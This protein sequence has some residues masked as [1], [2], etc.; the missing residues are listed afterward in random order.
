MTQNSVMKKSLYGNMF[1]VVLKIIGGFL[2]NSTALLADGVHSIS[3]LISDVFVLLGIKHSHKPADDDHPFGHGKFEYVLS[4]FLGL[5]IIFIAIELAINVIQDWSSVET[6]P[7]FGAL[8]LVIFVIVFKFFL[9]S[10][11]IKSGKTMDSQVIQASGKESLTDVVSSTV[12]LLGIALVI[13]GDH[14]NIDWMK[15]GDNVASIFIA[16][17]II[18]MGVMIAKD[19]VVSIQGKSVKKEI[20]NQ[21]RYC[22]EDVDGVIK[23]DH[24]DLIAYGPYYQAIVDIRVSGDITVKEGHDI[25]HEVETNLLNNEKIC[26]VSVHVN[27]E[28]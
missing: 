2:L 25:A 15:R 6:V 28:V 12:V 19:A 22:I 9:A 1:L 3:D 10:Y 16:L 23:V 11:L 5:S 8:L 14:L 4:L 21:Y 20:V 18:R 26:H 17:F 24:L 27:P 7:G 13:M